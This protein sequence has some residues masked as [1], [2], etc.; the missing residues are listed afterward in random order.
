MGQMTMTFSLKDWF[1]M[2]QII[3]LQITFSILNIKKGT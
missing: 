3:L 1:A 2:N